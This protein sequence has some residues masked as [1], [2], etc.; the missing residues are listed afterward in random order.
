V[1]ASP[2]RYHWFGPAT[3]TLTVAITQASGS[4][5]PGGTV[6]LIYNGSVLA[7]ATVQVFHGVATARFNI[8]F[9][10][11]GSFVFTVN[12]LGSTYFQKS[13]SKPLTVTV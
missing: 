13:S 10:M 3:T 12:Y 8:A 1:T 7:T 9:Y 5:A 6:Q 2:V 4:V 11:N